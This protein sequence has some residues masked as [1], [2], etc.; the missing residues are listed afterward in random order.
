[1]IE[2]DMSTVKADYPEIVKATRRLG[3]G[4]RLFVG[5]AGFEERSL[6]WVRHLC[7]QKP[8]SQAWVFKYLQPKGKNR[9]EE[10]KTALR[11]LGAKSVRQIPYRVMAPERIEDV[12]AKEFS[13]LP[14]AEVVLDIT[15]MTKLLILA[16]LFSLREFAGT[17]RIVYSEAEDY[18]PSRA[19][20]ETFKDD[21]RILLR[22]PSRGAESIVRLRCLSSIRMQGQPVSLVAFTSF[23][24]QLVRALLGAVTPRRLLLI[25][26]RPP[27]PDYGWREH[28]TQEIHKQYIEEFKADNAVDAE[29]KLLRVASTLDYRDTV[30]RLDEIYREVGL[31]ERIICGTTGS[32]MQTVGLFFGKVA[33]PDVHVEYPTPDS[34]FAKGL[35]SG[36]RRVH[37]VV[38]PDLGGFVRRIGQTVD[39]ARRN[40]SSEAP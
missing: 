33:H 4:D 25:N 13:E 31:Y 35:S 11:E 3:D 38:F 23:N 6:G 18:C 12:L 24:E 14:F 29:D 39:G 19:E 7:G 26:G 16:C 10:L 15:A 5:A 27:R 1:M 36:V 2:T 22:Y 32:K 17:L 40:P 21:S 9:V 28:A 8:L 20:Y 30:D 34:Y 37:E